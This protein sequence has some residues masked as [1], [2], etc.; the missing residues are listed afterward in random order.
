MRVEARPILDFLNKL[1]PG[2]LFEEGIVER[3]ALA[4]VKSVSLDALK[5]TE[6]SFKF[7]PKV[8]TEEKM[9]SIQYSKPRKL[10]GRIKNCMGKNSFL[11]PR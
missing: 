6:S 7:T 10:L 5:K 4:K 1:Y 3:E 2:E 11:P 8:R 9:V